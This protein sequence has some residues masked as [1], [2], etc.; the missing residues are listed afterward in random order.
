MSRKLLQVFVLLPLALICLAMPQHSFAST[1]A[2][3]PWPGQPGNPVGYAAWTG[4]TGSFNTTP[5]PSSPA[6]GTSWSN[7]TVVQNC[8][9]AGDVAI[10]CSYCEFIHVD[11]SGGSGRGNRGVSGSHVLLIGDRFQS[12]Y[13]EASSVGVGGSYIYFFYDSFEPLV[14]YYTS[15]PGSLWPSAGAGANSTKIT[16][17]VDAINGNEGYQFGVILGNGSG[18]IWI[19]HCDFWGFGNAITILTT[20]APMTIT[21]NWIHDAANPTEQSYHTDGIGFLNGNTAPNNVAIIGNTVAMLGNTNALALQAATGGYQNIHVNNNFW[22]GDGATIAFCHPG[23]VQCANSTFYGNTFGTDVE[24][25]GPLY[26]PGASLGTG[27]VWACNTIEVRSGTTWAN[28][29]NGQYFL[30]AVSENSATDQGGNTYC[31][32]TAPSAIQFG[33]YAAG[34]TSAGKAI[35]ISNTNTGNLSIASIALAGG[36]GSPFTITSNTCGSMLNS[37]SS[38]SITVIFAPTSMGPQTDTLL[39]RDNTAGVSSP[40]LVPLAGIGTAGSS[41]APPSGL[42]GVVQ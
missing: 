24:A 5:C 8:T 9:Y 4:W 25:G 6:S 15:P 36:A 32:M 17:G 16:E 3:S 38:C 30:N 2:Q 10:N 26:D 19:D 22:S 29:V 28:F 21:N 7:A 23:S 33:K 39:I 41:V 40:Q 12:N 14:S 13:V 18:P 1:T 11:F 27:S 37:G 42:N 20:I 35:T 31:A 34:T